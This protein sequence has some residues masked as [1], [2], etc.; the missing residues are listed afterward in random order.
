MSLTELGNISDELFV[1][2]EIITSLCLMAVI[3]Y[4][5]HIYSS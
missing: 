4:R 3:M 2:E 5:V 1:E